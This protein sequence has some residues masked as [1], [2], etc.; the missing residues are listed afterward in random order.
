M[1]DHNWTADLFMQTAPPLLT[2]KTSRADICPSVS[3]GRYV[4]QLYDLI[5]PILTQAQQ[6]KAYADRLMQGEALDLE[7]EGLPP[8]L[9][10]EWLAVG[11][12]PK[13]KRCMAVT[14]AST[15]TS[16]QGRGE[17]RITGMRQKSNIISSRLTV[18][19]TILLAR[20]TGKPLLRQNIPVLPANCVLDCIY[21]KDAAALFVVDFLQWK[22][23]SVAEGEAEFR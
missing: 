5:S 17:Y 15:R 13:G 2:R 7:G 12:V 8:D 14:F 1:L 19:N 6:Y 16:R 23:Q 10:G 4:T 20:T 11:P 9:A 3:E 22:G 18:T 21:V